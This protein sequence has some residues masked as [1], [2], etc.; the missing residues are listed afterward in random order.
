MERIVQPYCLAAVTKVR[1]TKTY[2]L[3]SKDKVIFKDIRVAY[4]KNHNI[5]RPLPLSSASLNRRKGPFESKETGF[6]CHCIGEGS[7]KTLA[8]R[9]QRCKNK[10]RAQTKFESLSI[11]A[12]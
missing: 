10:G 5:I 6:S 2:P 7:A 4:K 9:V 8:Y 1:S 12:Q 3:P 11:D